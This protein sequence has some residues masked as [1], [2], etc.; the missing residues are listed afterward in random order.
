MQGRTEVRREASEGEHR[1]AGKKV[2]DAVILN[3]RK[4]LTLGENELGGRT[5]VLRI[6]SSKGRE[7]GR[8]VRHGGISE[9]DSG[10]DETPGVPKDLFGDGRSEGMAFGET[11]LM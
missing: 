7:G 2:G 8:R 1:R 4:I 11:K 6:R 10:H 3:S 5:Q 9:K